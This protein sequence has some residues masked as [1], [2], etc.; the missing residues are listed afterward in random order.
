MIARV[1]KAAR[2]EGEAMGETEAADA[3]RRL[4][5]V[6][7][8]LFPAEQARIVQL[9]VERIDVRL[10]G[11]TLRLRAEGLSSLAAE[12][13]RQQPEARAA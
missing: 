7:D 4:D 8:E 5:P 1:W 11:V 2:R 12:L 6:W 9:L 3:L 10:D 13:R